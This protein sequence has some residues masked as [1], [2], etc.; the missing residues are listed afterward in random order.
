MFK[1]LHQFIN[2]DGILRNIVILESKEEIWQWNIFG[3]NYIKL[4]FISRNG[5]ILKFDEGNLIISHF[6]ATFTYYGK[7]YNLNRTK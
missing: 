6:G 4:N 5:N 2:E 3:S 7:T 1:I